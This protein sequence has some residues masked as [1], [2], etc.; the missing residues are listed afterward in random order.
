MS[1][2]RRIIQLLAVPGAFW[3]AVRW[4]VF[5]LAA[6]QMVTRLNSLGIRP[7]I[8]ID[9]GANI[10][11]FSTAVTQIFPDASVYAIEPDPD[12]ARTL[13][14]NFSKSRA[15]SVLVAAVG[16]SDS[17]A[18]FFHNSDP[19]AS[20]ILQLGA[21]RQREF[22]EGKI[23]KKSLVKVVTLDTLFPDLSSVSPILLKVDVQGYEDRVIAGAVRTLKNVKWV[24]LEM[25]F[26]KLYEEERDF[27]WMVNEME[28]YGFK[29]LQPLDFHISPTTD[30]IIEM[31]ALFERF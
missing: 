4:R 17:T 9:V 16:E 3:A 13:T 1:R 2:I 8:V 25:S 11:Q 15:V 28:R 14:R 6:F 30:L 10:G 26:A 20:S 31:D 12:C 18:T 7:K 24:V 19:Q 22:P 21:G 23:L 5:S 27:S 29:F